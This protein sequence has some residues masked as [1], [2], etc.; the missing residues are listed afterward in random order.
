M[1]PG[2]PSRRPLIEGAKLARGVAIG[3]VAVPLLFV[4]IGLLLPK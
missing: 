3:L 4:V 2:E 1:G